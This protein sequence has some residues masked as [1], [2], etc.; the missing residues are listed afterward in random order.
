[1]PEHRG[2][3]TGRGAGLPPTT[4]TAP[5]RD[6][7]EEHTVAIYRIPVELRGGDIPSPAINVWHARVETAGDLEGVGTDPSSGVMQ[8]LKEFYTAIAG[9]MAGDMSIEFPQ[10]VVEVT[11]QSE[12][13]VAAVTPVLTG[14]GSSAPGGLAMTVSWGTSLR[15]RRGRGRTFLGP[16]NPAVLGGDGRPTASV[17]TQF[18][19][20]ANTLLGRSTGVN[21]WALGVWGQESAGVLLPKVLRDFTSAK[22]STQFAHL[23]SR[24][25]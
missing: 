24:R 19:N 5:E 6:T 23:R 14:A 12:Q 10:S 21:G 11:D 4:G 22:V 17:V 20:A 9:A 15:A 13:T 3:S 7:P 16:L 8:A 1:M 2:L 25:D 18:Q